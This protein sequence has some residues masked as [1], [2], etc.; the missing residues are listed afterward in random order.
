MDQA[1]VGGLL[2][3]GEG[4][5]VDLQGSSGGYK[6]KETIYTH[7]SAKLCKIVK[8][9]VVFPPIIELAKEIRK[10]LQN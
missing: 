3:S 8:I 10:V 5:A 2:E 6:S 1:H 9:F 4:A 7:K